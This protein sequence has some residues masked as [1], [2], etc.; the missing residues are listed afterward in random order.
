VAAGAAEVVWPRREDRSFRA[1]S[2]AEVA[3]ARAAGTHKFT[4]KLQEPALQR[5]SDFS[6]KSEQLPTYNAYSRDG[7]VTARWCM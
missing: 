6:Q 7:D 2:D 1:L 3:Q 5:R 4:A